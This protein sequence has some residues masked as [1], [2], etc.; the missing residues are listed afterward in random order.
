MNVDEFNILIKKP[1]DVSVDNIPDLREM[2]ENYPFFTQARL[3]YVKALLKSGNIHTERNIKLA[4]V[5]CTNKHWFFYYL[6]PEKKPLGE[7]QH[8]E[9]IPKY[10][11]SYFDLLENAGVDEQERN[12]TLKSLAER[13]K[14]ARQMIV[15]DKVKV[16]PS[17]APVTVK[18]PV[19]VEFSLPDYFP[20]D[21]VNDL[22]NED[23]LKKYIL[24]KKYAEAIEI[25][26]KLNL[27]NPKKS[28]YF[29][30][31]IRFLEKVIA[32]SKK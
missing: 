7:S 11:G 30:D 22:V 19:K 17:N 32:N 3:L 18:K 5:Y 9:R 28:V 10:T 31:Q 25:L 14:E 1:E 29:A 24:E 26:K 15:D 2:I 6:Y 21:T 8:H 23:T 27:I 20:D 16:Q 4:S 13:L 12:T